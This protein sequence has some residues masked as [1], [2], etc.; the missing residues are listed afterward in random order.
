[1]CGK[2][3]PESSGNRAIDQQRGP[4]NEVNDAQQHIFNTPVLV[5][6]HGTVCG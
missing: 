1:M 5:T 3:G 6:P 2:N 4:L